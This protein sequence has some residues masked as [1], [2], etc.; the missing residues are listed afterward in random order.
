[1]TIAEERGMYVVTNDLP[2][3]PYPADTKVKGW[4]FQI[5]HERL[6]ASDTWA[7]APPDMRPWLLMIW[8]TAWI[9]QPAGAFSNDY[10]VIAAKIGME[11][12]LFSAHADI[13][14][15]GFRLHSDGRLYHQVVVEQVM[16]LLGLKEAERQRKADWRRKQAEKS[17][18]PTDVPRDR[19]G[20][21]M[22]K[23]APEPVPGPGPGPGPGPEPEKEKTGRTS[24]RAGARFTPPTVEEVLVFTQ[25]QG[26]SVDAQRFVDFYAS[27]GWMVGRNKMKD[28]KAAARNWARSSAGEA[29][30]TEKLRSG[31]F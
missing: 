24:T 14:L 2:D 28:W 29:S 5:D 18:C 17:G 8:H 12:R 25:E 15:R 22:G 20:T 16:G 27:K 11:P 3:P 10:D 7:L 1:M 21:D 26:L 19:H 30:H 13:L 6:F 31:D 9:Q 4:R 23:T